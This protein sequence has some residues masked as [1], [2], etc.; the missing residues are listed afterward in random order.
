MKVCSYCNGLKHLEQQCPA[1]K[2][3]MDDQGKLV[4]YLD[5]YSPYLDVGITKMVDGD[6]Q[7]VKSDHCIHVLRCKSC[8]RDEVVVIEEEP[9]EKG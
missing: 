5:D 8:D 4:D 2:N 3:L 6:R 7:S 9:I 1:C